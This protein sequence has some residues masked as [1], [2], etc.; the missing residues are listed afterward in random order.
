VTADGDDAC[1]IWDR[2]GYKGPEEI[3][4]LKQLPLT[5][6]GTT[7]RLALRQLAADGLQTQGVCT[8]S[9]HCAWGRVRS[10][11]PHA[12]ALGPEASTA[13]NRQCWRHHSGPPI[14]MA[15]CT[16]REAMPVLT[17]LAHLNAPGLPE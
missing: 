9:N 13:K 16:Q 7:D 8:N 12:A 14:R 2:M 17:Q 6:V 5:P 10:P 4:V 15:D 3:R 11:F 1:V